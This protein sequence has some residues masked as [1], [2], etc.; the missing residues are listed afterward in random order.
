MDFSDIRYGQVWED[1][2]VLLDG[3]D[4]QPGGTY[5]SVA[6]AGDNALALLVRN[7]AHVIAVDLSP[8]QLACLE[9]RVAAFRALSHAEV[10]EIIGS[11]P[12]TRRR[13][14]YARC[15]SQ[16]SADTRHFWDR[17]GDAIDGGI[18]AAG[19]LERYFELF[20]R[21]VLPLVHGRRLIEQLLAPRDRRER[22]D[23]YAHRWDTPRWR[24]LFKTFFSRFLMGRLGRH[25]EM[26]RYAAG[27][28]AERLLDR[29]RHALTELEPARN[30]YLHWILTGAHR[31]TLPLA[32]RPESFEAIRRN[33]DRLEWRREPLEQFVRRARPA[34]FDGFNL[35]DVFEY[36]PADDYRRTLD[37]IARAG[38]PGARLAYWN[39]LAPRR[40]AETPSSPVRPLG[41]LAARLHRSDC[42]FFYSDFVLE[43]VA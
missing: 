40:C 10:L 25:P 13:C 27:S 35:S 11:R 22:E 37:D 36:V 15:R 9:L 32:L 30:P 4:V 17:R 12:S 38:R 39:L 20:R 31:E 33:L 7:P 41:D 29:T 2:D 21:Q 5:L 42:G 18:G 14:L 26:F 6:S 16:L 28:V 24:L 3:L 8:A 43:E 1:A 34:T 19:R 23:F